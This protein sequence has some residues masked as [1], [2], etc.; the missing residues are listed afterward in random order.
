MLASP[1]P[2]LTVHPPALVPEES[3][4]ITPVVPAGAAEPST[5]SPS[6]EMLR[7]RLNAA[8]PSASRNGSLRR[9]S[10]FGALKLSLTDDERAGKGPSR[11]PTLLLDDVNDDEVGLPLALSEGTLVQTLMT[12][13]FARHNCSRMTCS[14]PSPRAA[15]GQANR[16]FRASRQDPRSSQI[17][18]R[19]RRRRTCRSVAFG[20]SLLPTTTV[21]PV[22]TTATTSRSHCRSLGLA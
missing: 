7:H 6:V 11:F 22:A 16:P 1:K 12:S 2:H 10:A 3:E 19:A 14:R 5:L 15:I 20:P 4:P 21:G 13:P 9:P 8:R 18:V 17:C